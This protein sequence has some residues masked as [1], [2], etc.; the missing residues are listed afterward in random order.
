MEHI[1]SFLCVRYLHS[2]SSRHFPSLGYIH[3]QLCPI[4]ADG[5][6]ILARVD[7]SSRRY[8][9]SPIM[10][11]ER[12]QRQIDR[13][14][15]EAEEAITSQDWATVGDRARSV[16]RL[17]PENQDALSYLAAAERD[18]PP[19]ITQPAAEVIFRQ[20][21]PVDATASEAEANRSRARLEQ[22][23]PKELL[24]KLEGTRAKKDV[25]SGERR[26]VTMMFCDV[27]GSTSA[28]ER[29][30]PEEWAEI[31]N[32]AFEYLIA[33]VYRYEGTLARLMGDAILAFFGAPIA[34]EDD[35]QRA[36]LAGLDIVQGIR[37]YQAEVK[38][39]W[40]LDFGVRVGINT[41][42]V[43]VGDVGSDLRVEY[44]AMGDAINLAARMEQT[45]QT[46][47]VQV[48]AD[49]RN[50]ITPLF[51]F[52][53]LGEIEVKGK[54][55]PVL[56]YRV[57]GPKAIPG[58]LRGIEGLHVPLVGRDSEISVLRQ[59]LTKLH[60]GSGSIVCLIG[61][62]G[63]GK[64]RLIEELHAEWEK[65]AASGSPWMISQGVSYDT[66]RPYGLFMQSLRQVYGIEDSDP[67]ELIREKVERTPDDFPP[68]VKMLV[69]RV[70]GALLAIDAESDG[71]Q[72]HGEA[73]QHELYQACQNVLRASASL[74]PTVLV[75]DDLHWA[76]PASVELMIE[77]F[78]LVEEL[79]LLLLCSFRPE[80]QSPAWRVK[81]TA[82]TDYPHRYTEIAL[83][84]LSDV[85]SD[86]L[87]GNL[88]NIS[89]S[90]PELRPMILQRTEGNP[91]YLEEF[92]R[93]LIDSGVVNRDETGLHWSP[94]AKV[95]DI[96]I[97]ESLQALLTSRI[98]RLTE[99]ARRTLQLSS[100]IGRSFYHRVL[101]L[102]SDS[103]IPLDQQLSALQRA[104]LIRE[105]GRV[106]ELEY[107]F[108]HD[109]TREAA[110]SSILL[111]E[112]R[113][114][115]RRVGE[116]VEELFNNRLEE[117]SHL[118]ANHFYQAGDKDR[119]LKYSSMAGDVAARLYANAEA[120]THYTRAIELVDSATES[121]EQ[122]VQL[123]IARGR[124][125][126]LVGEFE[127][128]LANYR[129]LQSFAEAQGDRGMELAALIPQ[130]T[131]H[132]TNNAK[133]N[134]ETGRDLSN[135]GLLLARELND[136]QAE[137]KVLWNL[138]LLEYYEGQD[139]EQ[140]IAYG[141]QSQAIA[142]RLGL[143]EQLAYTLNDLARAYFT[144]GKSDLAWAAQKESAD[145]LR[146]LG[147]LPMLTDSLITSA[148]GHY[149]LGEFGEALSAAEECL[150]VSRSIGSIWGQA[151]SLYVLGAIYMESGDIGKSVDVL[152]EA[153]P[154]AKQAGFA[155]GVT[156]RLRLALFCGMLGETEQGLGLAR[157]ALEEG[158]NRQF[159]LAAL[160][161]FHLCNGDPKEAD[162]AL[163]EASKE[164]ESGESDPKAGYAI[165]QVIEGDTAL[166]N[167]QYDRALAL[168][169]RTISS[170]RE[171]GQRVFLPDMLRCQGESLFG[172]GRI[173]EAKATLEEA[174]A[175]AEKQGSRRAL[176]CILPALARLAA[177]TGATTEAESL[178][179]R[180][181]EVIGYIADQAGTPELREAYLNST[182]MKELMSIL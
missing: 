181:R 149:F 15:D 104:E 63:I 67:P 46:G 35:P 24:A 53:N 95:E 94:E 28:A 139:R 105:A 116:A 11:S 162:A 82:E 103:S 170:L 72:L 8:Y 122:R 115:H 171:M 51:E 151:V 65:I 113:E 48:S 109:L 38:S 150:G 47:T 83:S 106:P 141:E 59:V 133:F 164:F 132:S 37:A 76:D 80:R 180:A 178:R 101:K 174:L 110:Y 179:H 135:K 79:P 100:V 142:R 22:Y 69:V 57:I 98:D 70:V 75:L 124:T 13:L 1:C 78:P 62:A 66:T 145:L 166:A 88:F 152:K 43:V 159:A 39:N 131:I 146:E 130:A 137:A 157:L 182:K 168:T 112:R 92:T 40:N 34:H 169:D 85:D 14:L 154:L 136:H 96:S 126:E 20:P 118:L 74:A 12:I 58:T 93:T 127:Q 111:R 68:Q 176:W 163:Q 120:I 173:T 45:A 153:L 108:R 165:F 97:P 99:D 73:L 148:G 175:E 160:A 25:A 55:E 84:A 161:Q 167:K 49:T 23:I 119:A 91:L 147:N 29:L 107:I 5:L 140:A 177:H 50:L 16:L 172:L 56:A 30:D 41:G 89:G 134:R 3:L 42:L 155:P 26:V 86:V 6:H 128:A 123:Y 44:T 117:Q 125:L 60:Q 138:M 143:Q 9:Y 129:E 36:V 102:I 144:V 2:K 21:P 52:E 27:T 158:D 17:D 19:Q 7:E 114:F 33:P 90:P 10:A 87:F 71:P 64:S 121:R 81:Q 18:L 77:T 31:M 54:D 32:G 156:V 61:E 4:F